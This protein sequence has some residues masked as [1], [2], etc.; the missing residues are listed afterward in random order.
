MNTDDPAQVLLPT[1]SIRALSTLS[2]DLNMHIRPLLVR[3]GLPYLS[4]QK[5]QLHCEKDNLAGTPWGQ[6]HAVLASPSEID[7]GQGEREDIVSCFIGLFLIASK[8]GRYVWM[9]LEWNLA[10]PTSSKLGMIVSTQPWS[11]GPY[12]LILLAWFAAWHQPQ[13]YSLGPPKDV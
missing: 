9:Q 10:K 5:R 4:T 6:Q 8:L 2:V 1:H 12:N 3:V 7:N 13:G 11:Y